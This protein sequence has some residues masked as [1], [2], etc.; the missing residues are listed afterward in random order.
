MTMNDKQAQIVRDN[1]QRVREHIIR[2]A[3]SIG[4]DADAIKLLVVT[5]GHP[6]EIAQAGD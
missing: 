3:Q 1:Y 6:I 4:R 5:K 2:T